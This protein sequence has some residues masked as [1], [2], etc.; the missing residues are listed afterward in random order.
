MNPP[1]RI[2]N[3][4]KNIPQWQKNYIRTKIFAHRI[5]LENL[6]RPKELEITPNKS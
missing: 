5:Y 3:T 2:N 1:N 4:T 6:P